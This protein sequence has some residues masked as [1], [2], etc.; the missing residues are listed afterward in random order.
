MQS[1]IK[2]YVLMI[3]IHLICNA[4]IIF[5]HNFGAALLLVL[6]YGISKIHNK[7]ISE[8]IILLITPLSQLPDKHLIELFEYV[9]EKK[10]TEKLCFRY[11]DDY[12]TLRPNFTN[13]GIDQSETKTH[14]PTITQNVARFN[15][16]ADFRRR[17]NHG[18]LSRDFFV[19]IL[20]LCDNKWALQPRA[21]WQWRLEIRN[22]WSGWFL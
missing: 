8:E 20:A 21:W 13:I 2:L 12:E 7:D 22:T 5:W 19:E 14:L 1:S 10:W 3:V 17:A 15:A 6:Q 11:Q 16:N 4:E 9:S 18:K